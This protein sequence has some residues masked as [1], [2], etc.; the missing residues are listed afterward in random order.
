MALMTQ[1]DLEKFATG[2][3]EKA[4]IL[5]ESIEITQTSDVYSKNRTEWEWYLKGQQQALTDIALQLKSM[6]LIDKINKV[7]E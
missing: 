5:D 7:L 2:L 3:L 6:I 1:D 4:R